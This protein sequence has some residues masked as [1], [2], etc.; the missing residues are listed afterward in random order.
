MGDGC[1]PMSGSEFGNLCSCL[2]Q[3]TCLESLWWYVDL[4]AHEL[5][6][7]VSAL[8]QIS[9]LKVVWYNDH[10]ILTDVGIRQVKQAMNSSTVIQAI[11]DGTIDKEKLEEIIREWFRPLRSLL[12]DHDSSQ[13]LDLVTADMQSSSHH[14]AGDMKDEE[15]QLTLALSASV[16]TAQDEERRRA[17]KRSVERDEDQQEEDHESKRK[18]LESEDDLEMHAPSTIIQSSENEQDLEIKNYH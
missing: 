14:S 16:Q 9:S 4:S 7:L 11:N 3:S 17:T 1:R 18:A 6:E 15:L 5:K 10:A 8:E 13:S 2:C 12:S